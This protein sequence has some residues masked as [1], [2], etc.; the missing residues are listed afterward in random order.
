MKRI[1]ESVPLASH[2]LNC[3]VIYLQILMNDALTRVHC[4]LSSEGVYK[5]LTVDQDLYNTSS[6][7]TEHPLHSTMNKKVYGRMKD[8][9]M[10]IGPTIAESVA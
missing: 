10:P 7:W 5:D 4:L 3:K 2:L 6:F 8:G 1:V 9:R